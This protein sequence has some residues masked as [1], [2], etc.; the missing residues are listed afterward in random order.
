MQDCTLD[1]RLFIHNDSVCNVYIE[2]A[3]TIHAE[4]LMHYPFAYIQND[5]LLD[6]GIGH[7]K[8]L[9]YDQKTGRRF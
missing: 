5:Q 9:V 6:K 1:D 2:N 7:S 3:V 8:F 4:S